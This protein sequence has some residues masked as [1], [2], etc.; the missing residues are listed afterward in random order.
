MAPAPPAWAPPGWVLRWGWHWVGHGLQP[1]FGAMPSLR[2]CHNQVCGLHPLSSP[3]EPPPFVCL[4][5]HPSILLPPLL[6]APGRRHHRLRGAPGAAGDHHPCDYWGCGRHRRERCVPRGG[7][8]GVSPGWM[9]KNKRMLAGVRDDSGLCACCTE[10]WR[11]PKCTELVPACTCLPCQA[12]ATT[13]YERRE[14]EYERRRWGRIRLPHLSAPRSAI[15]IHTVHFAPN[16][17]ALLRKQCGKHLCR[18]PAPAST[19]RHVL[20]G[21]HPQR[22][23]VW[24][25]LPRVPCC[26]AA[27]RGHPRHCCGL[28]HHA[29]CGPPG[30]GGES[31]CAGRAGHPFADCQC[32]AVESV[33]QH[34]TAPVLY[35]LQATGSAAAPAHKALPGCS[36]H[37]PTQ[38]VCGQEFFTKVRRAAINSLLRPPLCLCCIA[39]RV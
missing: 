18:V 38:V 12:A 11:L 31:G 7:P 35:A 36:A 39:M 28:R 2:A 15:F 20:P 16:C 8:G 5:T 19:H 6:R 30:R 3:R 32:S 29:P 23:G 4:H 22:A 17:T 34:A 37:P 24:R 33:L 10:G 26:G 1:K 14:D 27:D 13:G 25:G 9:L 21:S